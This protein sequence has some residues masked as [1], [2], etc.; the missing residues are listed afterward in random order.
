MAALYYLFKIRLQSDK[1]TRERYA[2]SCLVASSSLV[3]IAIGNLSSREGIADHIYDFV[4]QLLGQQPSPPEPASVVEQLSITGLVLFGIYQIW[5]SYRDWNG[6]RSVDEVQRRRKNQSPSVILEGVD[7]A[8][9]LVKRAPPRQIYDK[10]SIPSLQAILRSPLHD[11]VWH[12]HARQL[13]EL[14][15]ANVI[16]RPENEDG[17]DDRQKCWYGLDRH[18]KKPII[19][20]CPAEPPTDADLD[21]LIRRVDEIFKEEFSLYVAV[22]QAA[23]ESSKVVVG[24]IQITTVTEK[25]LLDHIADFSDYCFDVTRRVE[26]SKLAESGLTI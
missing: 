11:V 8:V 18:T 7:E 16:F 21:T 10:N 5:R 6:L 23:Q 24:G 2:F 25:Y 1:Y 12:E 19:L 14:W 4:S 17:W 9:R 13:F 15:E 3:S 22:R 26:D 20:F